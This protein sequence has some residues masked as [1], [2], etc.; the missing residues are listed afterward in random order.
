MRSESR[1]E[2]SVLN[3]ATLSSSG[4]VGDIVITSW[5]RCEALRASA[6]SSIDRSA[7]SFRIV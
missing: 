3:S 5:K 7:C 4:S 1:A 6:S 2:S